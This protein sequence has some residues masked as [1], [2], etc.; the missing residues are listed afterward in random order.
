[1]FASAK[2]KIRYVWDD[3]VFGFV[4]AGL[5]FLG[6]FIKEDESEPEEDDWNY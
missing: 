1:M 6:F 2:K 4:V 5:Y 3:I